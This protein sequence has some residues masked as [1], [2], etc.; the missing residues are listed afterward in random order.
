MLWKVIN[1]II[2]PLSPMNTH[3]HT[4]YIGGEEDEKSKIV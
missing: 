1:S 3:K 2:F 4:Q